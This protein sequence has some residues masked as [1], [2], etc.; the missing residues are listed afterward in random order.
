M[1]DPVLSN[2][3]QDV[4]KV[5]LDLE[6]LKKVEEKIKNRD[7]T[8][9]RSKSDIDLET[10]YTILATNF[11]S[12]H[13][14]DDDKEFTNVLSFETKPKSGVPEYI[15]SKVLQEIERNKETTYQHFFQKE[16]IARKF[17]DLG[18]TKFHVRQI[19]R[20]YLGKDEVVS[21]YSPFDFFNSEE[22][23]ALEKA[24]SDL[25]TDT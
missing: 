14:M 13:E 15:P 11:S 5:T 3:L 1:I 22:G 4:Q 20:Q 25:L 17:L 19:S 21:K 16:E 12:Y 6:F 2:H 10:P 18:F 8:K 7:L 23:G 9:I 24:I